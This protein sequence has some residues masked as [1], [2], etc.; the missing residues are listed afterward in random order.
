[1][2]AEFHESAELAAVFAQHGSVKVLALLLVKECFDGLAE[3]GRAV[4]LYRFSD[5]IRG[6]LYFL[7]D[8]LSAGPGFFLGG[9]AILSPT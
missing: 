3:R 8:Q 5:C 4:G 1:M 7:F 6:E 9:A 2:L